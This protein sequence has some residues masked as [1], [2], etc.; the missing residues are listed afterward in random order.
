MAENQSAATQQGGNQQFAIQKIYIK[1]VSFE[2]PNSP[3]M[4]TK[5][6]QPEVNLDM[7]TNTQALSEGVFEV[8]LS[9]TATVKNADQTAF[10]VEVQQAGIFTINGFA[11]ND[12]GHMLGSF[13][14][15]ILFPYAR[16][17][18]SDLVTKG[19]YPPLILAP[20]NFDAL[21][22]QHLAQQQQA[23]KTEASTH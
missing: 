5:E 23:G 19:G 7:N 10:L 3:A 15:N 16:E 14:P 22:A 9:L 6:W 8:V 17:A 20:V 12:M 11:E 2:S 4:F 21:Y 1:D 18:V 13:C